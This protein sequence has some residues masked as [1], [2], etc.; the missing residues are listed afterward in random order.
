MNG[1]QRRSRSFT[2]ERS[3]TG[4]SQAP[5]MLHH[6]AVSNN[7]ERTTAL[8]GRKPTLNLQGRS[9]KLTHPRQTRKQI[10]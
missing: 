4:W 3:P 2:F 10:A 5:P 7:G 6:C 1:K 9:K 8:V